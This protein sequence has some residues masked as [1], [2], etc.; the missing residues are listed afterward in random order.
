VNINTGA[1]GLDTLDDKTE[2][3]FPTLSKTVA[4]GPGTVLASM[5]GMIDYPFA[6]CIM[7]PTVGMFAVPDRPVQSPPPPAPEPTAD[8]PAPAP[9]PPAGNSGGGGGA[10]QAAPAPTQPGVTQAPPPPVAPA[11]P[12]LA[13]S[14]VQGEIAHQS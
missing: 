14:V 10:P 3:G 6:H 13:G 7:T 8:A 5:W 4:S 11:A 12:N 2:L 9:A 1:S